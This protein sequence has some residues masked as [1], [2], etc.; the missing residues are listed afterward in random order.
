MNE[1]NKHSVRSLAWKNPRDVIKK[2][3]RKNRHGLSVSSSSSSSS[4][5]QLS[6]ESEV[7]DGLSMFTAGMAQGADAIIINP[8]RH[9]LWF[10]ASILQ[11]IT[12]PKS[13]HE[14]NQWW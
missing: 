9:G 4:L 1:P 13:Y 14:Q 3:I 8:F 6:S 11:K 7:N 5:K 2:G 12:Q 10:T